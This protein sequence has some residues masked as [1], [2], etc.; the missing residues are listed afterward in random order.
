[1]E[2]GRAGKQERKGRRERR[3]AGRRELP[4]GCWRCPLRGGCSR[5]KLA[6]H[7][8]LLQ[9]CIQFK[10][11]E[12]GGLIVVS[13][14]A[15]LDSG[16]SL[17]TTVAPTTAIVNKNSWRIDLPSSSLLLPNNYGNATADF[18]TQVGLGTCTHLKQQTHARSQRHAARTNP[19]APRPRRCGRRRR[20]CLRAPAP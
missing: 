14:R 15:L 3:G 18:S 13:K 7:R 1:M 16:E 10:E 11:S 4:C 12:P 20:T 2:G 19:A 9:M 8:H 6:R 17:C 5:S